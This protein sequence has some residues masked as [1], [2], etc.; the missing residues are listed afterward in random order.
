MSSFFG[1]H[2]R[3]N[4][5]DEETAQPNNENLARSTD[6]DPNKKH[7]LCFEDLP[8]WINSQDKSKYEKLLPLTQR[9]N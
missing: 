7:L 2:P 3:L 6:S 5:N 8:T 1:R 9:N 4:S